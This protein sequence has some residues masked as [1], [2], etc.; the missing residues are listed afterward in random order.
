MSFIEV[1]DV[2]KQYIQ[3]KVIFNALSH[4]SLTIHKGEFICILGPSGCGKTTL[5]NSLAGFEC[6]DS[7]SINIDGEPVTNPRP[8]YVTIF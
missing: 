7:G 1:Q 4:V 6:M 8:E 5:L 3:G 2:S